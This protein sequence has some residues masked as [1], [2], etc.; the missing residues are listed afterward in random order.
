M[1]KLI[2]KYPMLA[3]ILIWVTLVGAVW[4][5]PSEPRPQ[6]AAAHLAWAGKLPPGL[7]AVHRLIITRH[8]PIAD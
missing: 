6:A 1:G 3:L 8:R 5:L 7:A 4:L 2:G